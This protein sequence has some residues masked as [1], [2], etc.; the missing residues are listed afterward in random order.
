[1]PPALVA[2]GMAVA[3]GV[4]GAAK[5]KA[6]ADQ[7]NQALQGAAEMS[8][9]SPWTKMNA[10]QAIQ[11][12]QSMEGANYVGD[13]IQGGTSGAMTG[14]NMGA[15]DSWNSMLQQKMMGQKPG[16]G[17]MGND[18]LIKQQYSPTGFMSS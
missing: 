11:N 2:A 8:R 18:Q 9:Y 1:M 13:I 7:K 4:A 17:A 5:S 6:K 16:M 3:G 15:A 12:A 10:G 14:A